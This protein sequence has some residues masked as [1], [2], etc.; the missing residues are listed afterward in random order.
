MVA[1]ARRNGRSGVI[2]FGEVV[3]DPI[4]DLDVHCAAN[5]FPIQ[6]LSIAALHETQMR[7]SFSFSAMDGGEIRVAQDRN[8]AAISALTL[9]SLAFA[10]CSLVLIVAAADSRVFSF[11]DSSV[12]LGSGKNTRTFAQF[13]LLRLAITAPGASRRPTRDHRNAPGQQEQ[14]FRLYPSHSRECRQ[15]LL[16]YAHT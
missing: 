15:A 16:V 1:I 9:G 4:L 8:S 12:S 2:R 7:F 13:G 3:E 10:P 11:T 6:N 14:P 5:T